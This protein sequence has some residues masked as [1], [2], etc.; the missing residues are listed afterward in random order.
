MYDA[1]ERSP[2]ASWVRGDSVWVPGDTGRNVTSD[3]SSW[4]KMAILQVEPW[5]T[6]FYFGWSSE[7]Y[8]EI[9]YYNAPVVHVAGQFGAVVGDKAVRFSVQPADRRTLLQIRL[10]HSVWKGDNYHNLDLPYY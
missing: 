4:R 10:V 7:E 3:R 9:E 2:T 8:P 5:N 6:Q 1:K